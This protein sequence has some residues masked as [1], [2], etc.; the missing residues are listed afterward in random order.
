MKG[1]ARRSEGK[2]LMRGGV[3]YYFN[4]GEL[5]LMFRDKGA[6]LAH[7]MRRGAK[8]HITCGKSVHK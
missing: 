2:I 6:F 4:E 5:N 7:V 3:G 1:K 8:G